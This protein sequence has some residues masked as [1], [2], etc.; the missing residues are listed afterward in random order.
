MLTV[1]E[2]AWVCGDRVDEGGVWR[3]A[4]CRG[5]LSIGA[6]GGGKFDESRQPSVPPSNMQQVLGIRR[7][8]RQSVDRKTHTSCVSTRR[9]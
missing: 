8:V 7:G 2:R 1:R 5:T 6:P 9:W 3:E 4:V